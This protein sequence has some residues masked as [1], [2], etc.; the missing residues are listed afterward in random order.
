MLSENARHIAD[1]CRFCWMC[2]HLCPAGLAT[3]REVNTPRARGL[4]VS[5]DSRGI[6]LSADSVDAMFQCCL[7]GACTNDCATGWDPT[8]FIREARRDA[9]VRNLL[10]PAARQ[11]LDRALTGDISGKSPDKNLTAAIAALPKTAD[12]VL[13]LG[14]EGLRGGAASSMGLIATLRA[15]GTVFT[16]LRDEPDSGAIL[17]DLMGM[18]DDIRR[19]AEQCLDRI[20]AA[21]GKTV[22]AADPTCARFFKRECEEMGLLNGLAVV[23]ATAFV[24]ECVVSGKLTPGSLSV[25]SATFHDPCRLARDLDE[26]E[27]ARNILRALGISVTEMFLNRK[28]ATCCGGP[29][30]GALYPA[31]GADVATARWTDTV[32]AGEDVLITACP[33]CLAVMAA[34]APAGKRVMDIFALVAEAC[35]AH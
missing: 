27:S 17:Y 28:L 23:T 8:V 6:P 25:T 7:C 32:A 1:A 12:I 9:V 18:T 30:L 19:M 10:P 34:T 35:A 20:R 4:L 5:M 24:E 31:L 11:V 33:R 13:Y 16:V 15:A 29:V 22:I 3:G 14:S 2:R 26:T 21:G